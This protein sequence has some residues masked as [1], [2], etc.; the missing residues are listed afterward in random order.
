MIFIFAQSQNP[1]GDW[2]VS[3][4]VGILELIEEV[5]LSTKYVQLINL[6]KTDATCP[7]G[8]R[9]VVCGWGDDNS[10]PT[11]LT[12]TLWCVFQECLPHDK[13]T[14]SGGMEP[15]LLCVGDHIEPV[16]FGNCVGFRDSGGNIS[17]LID[18]SQQPIL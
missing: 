16:P 13:C 4:D 7:K 14:V 5:D 8:K 12:D 15:F 18:E 2:H 10:R 1:L 3:P 6:P 17:Y 9:L 11:R